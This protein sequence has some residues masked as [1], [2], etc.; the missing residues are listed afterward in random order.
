MDKVRKGLFAYIAGRKNDCG[1]LL[2]ISFVLL[3][4][5]ADDWLAHFRIVRIDRC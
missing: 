4:E 1:S 3:D 5:L 2:D